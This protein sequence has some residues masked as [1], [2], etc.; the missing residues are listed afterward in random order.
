MWRR[1]ARG[2]ADGEVLGAAAG[3]DEHQVGE[4]DDADDQEE[5]AAGLKQKQRGADGADMVGVKAA[6]VVWKPA[7]L[8]S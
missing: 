5:D 2:L 1:R 7:S 6:T 3:A 8:M 4:V